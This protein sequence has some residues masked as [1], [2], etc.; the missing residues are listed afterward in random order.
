[1]S[2]SEL[3]YGR[4]LRDFLP[5]CPSNFCRPKTDIFRQ[6]WNDIAEWRELALAKRCAKVMDKLALWTCE[7]FASPESRGFRSRSKPIGE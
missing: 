4:K 7:G 3:L 1:M 6:E 5:G 2:P